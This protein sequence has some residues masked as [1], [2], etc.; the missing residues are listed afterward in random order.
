MRKHW[1]EI[2]SSNEKKAIFERMS[3]DMAIC[4]DLKVIPFV[5]DIW[6]WHSSAGK[7]L[8]KICILSAFRKYDEKAFILFALVLSPILI[9]VVD[10]LFPFRYCKKNYITSVFEI[11]DVMHWIDFYASWGWQVMSIIYRIALHW[12]LQGKWRNFDRHHFLFQ[13]NLS[14]SIHIESV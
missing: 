9:A 12:I 5:R 14:I 10:T 2:K 4:L 8:I 3:S 11:H 6:N 1:S 13:K 7:E